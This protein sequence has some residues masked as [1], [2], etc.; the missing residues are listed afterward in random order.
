MKKNVFFAARIAVAALF[1]FVA[2]QQFYLRWYPL[3]L[4]VG[5]IRKLMFVY[6]L[7]TALVLSAA[8]VLWD[9]ISKKA[10]VFYAGVINLLSAIYFGAA[11]I[12]SWNSYLDIYSNGSASVMRYVIFAAATMAIYLTVVCAVFFIGTKVNRYTAAPV[13]TPEVKPDEASAETPEDKAEEAPEEKP[14]DE[15]EEESADEPEEKP[16]DEPEE[17]PEEEPV[18]ESDEKAEEPSEEKAEEKPAEKP[19]EDSSKDKPEEQEQAPE[20]ANTQ[21]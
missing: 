20:E 4:R 11:F 8:F 12:V 16:A 10:G 14:E 13:E 7:L 6:V 19:E 2:M 18:E 21:E 15:P 3:L 17:K 9:K 5:T 1:V